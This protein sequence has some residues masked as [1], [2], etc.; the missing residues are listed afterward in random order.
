M[1][2]KINSVHFDASERLEEFIQNKLNKLSVFLDSLQSAEVFLR[3]ENSQ[4]N[5]NKAVV[6]KLKAA[7][8]DFFAEKQSETF[9]KSTDL[10]IEALRRQ[11]KK[12][13]GKA[14]EN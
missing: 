13:K 12:H 4:T 14:D 6:I 2:I 9:E 11:L 10:A 1:N 5:E 3:V 7:G 8:E